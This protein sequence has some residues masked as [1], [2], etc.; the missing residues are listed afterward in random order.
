MDNRLAENIRRYR[1]DNNMTQEAL[2]E[3]LGI[4]LGTISKW[5]R[6]SSEPDVSSM[7]K[8]AE[9]FRISVDALLGFSLQGQDEETIVKRIRQLVDHRD[10]EGALRECN[11]ATLRFPNRF[12]VVYRVAVAHQLGGLV[13]GN[14]EWLRKAIDAYQHAMELFSQNDDPDINE[15]E[16]KNNIAEC[17]LRMEEYD[18]GVEELKRNN[19]CGINNAEIGMNLI[20]WLNRND[21]GKKYIGLAMVDNFSKMITISSAVLVY[22]LNLKDMVRCTIASGWYIDHMNSLKIRKN[23]PAFVDK[24]VAAYILLLSYCHF[25]T[26][27]RKS[28]ES[29][30]E[31]AIQKARAFDENPVYGLKNIVFLEHD[32][33]VSVY[34]DVGSAMD[35]LRRIIKEIRDAGAPGAEKFIRR[36]ESKLQEGKKHD[37]TV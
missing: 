4:T 32:V 30:L 17:Y 6:G 21:E 35:G 14:K 27:R 8:L 15:I 12:R 26:G 9:I 13:T 25:E 11:E 3:R 31:E 20:T 1:K 16:I 7:M 36:F 28:A 18:K 33:K 29:E 5:E 34:D 24:Y 2:A 10:F 19:I 22:C 23:E 37:E